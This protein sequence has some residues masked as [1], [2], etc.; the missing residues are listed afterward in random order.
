M[1]SL[2][3]P[4]DGFRFLSD[5]SL[6]QGRAGTDRSKKGCADSGSGC[7][8]KDACSGDCGS[9]GCAGPPSNALNREIDGG[10][11]ASE[12]PFV[13]TEAYDEHGSSVQGVIGAGLEQVLPALLGLLDHLEIASTL[14]LVGVVGRL[15]Q[16]QLRAAIAYLELHW[17][18]TQW[19]FVFERARS[20]LWQTASIATDVAQLVATVFGQHS[21]QDSVG[22]AAAGEIKYLNDPGLCNWKKAVGDEIPYCLSHQPACMACG[23]LAD[24][25]ALCIAHPRG[26]GGREVVC[27]CT[28][29]DGEKKRKSRRKY[30]DDHDS[31]WEPW[32]PVI[33]ITVTIVTAVGVAVLTDGVGTEA[34][35]EEAAE[36]IEAIEAATAAAEEEAVEAL[37]ME[38]IGAGG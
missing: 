24:E 33:L 36:A 25:A 16:D 31:W 29:G 4:S 20:S 8:C 14:D 21:M 3:R 11:W 23:G 17:P 35:G 1:E 28:G 32:V 38:E 7:N 34:A 19:S 15:T 22:L 27:G 18:G 13:V 5:G 6:G 9:V 2:M 12:D 26:P 37:E 30:H 10:S